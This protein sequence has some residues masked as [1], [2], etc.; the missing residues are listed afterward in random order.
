MLPLMERL[1]FNRR[2]SRARDYFASRFAHGQ[3]L[4]FFLKNAIARKIFLA[5]RTQK[6]TGL[7]RGT[8]ESG[9]LW[10]AQQELKRSFRDYRNPSFDWLSGHGRPPHLRTHRASAQVL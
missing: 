1:E 10:E 5:R 6:N 7:G 9:Q 8:A 3:V 4:E 2:Y